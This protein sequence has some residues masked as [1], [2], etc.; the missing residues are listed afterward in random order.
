M[1]KAITRTG[2]M[3]GAMLIPQWQFSGNLGRELKVSTGP[4]GIICYHHDQLSGF[5]K[6]F[7]HIFI[8]IILYYV[9]EHTFPSMWMW[10]SEDNLWE[11]VLSFYHVGFWELSWDLKPWLKTSLSTKPSYPTPFLR[12]FVDTEMSWIYTYWNIKDICEI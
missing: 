8:L 10:R 3:G 6:I 1:K 5:L 12:L 7:L 4:S 11:W 9:R 2:F